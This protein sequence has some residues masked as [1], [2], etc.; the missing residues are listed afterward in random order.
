[1]RSCLTDPGGMEA[2]GNLVILLDEVEEW[3]INLAKHDPETADQVEAAIDLLADEG[4]TRGRPLV[5]RIK[6]SGLHNLKELHPG[7]AGGSEVRV[8]FV[9]DPKRQAILLTAG[10]KTGAWKQWYK[11]N[12]PVAEK[13]YAAWLVCCT[14]SASPRCARTSRR[15]CGLNAWPKSARRRGKLRLDSLPS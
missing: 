13:R 14:K 6:G 4:P 11:D 10:D 1:M 2:S 5:D 8:L 12:I 7:P 9:F 15:L 3:L